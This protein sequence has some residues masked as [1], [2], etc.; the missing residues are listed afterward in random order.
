MFSLI[1]EDEN[2]LVVNLISKKVVY[3]SIEL[4]LMPAR[5]ALYAFFALQK[6]N[7]TKEVESYSSCTDCFLDI[8][9]IYEKQVQITDLYKRISG[10]RPI[11]EMSDTGIINLNSD[12]FIMYKGKIRQDLLRRFGPYALKELEV[13]SVGTRPNTTYGIMMDRSKIEIVY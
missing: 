2:R 5:M 7:C 1:K 4:D 3:K 9:S 11:D 10:T 13:A 12:N 6:K 8:Q